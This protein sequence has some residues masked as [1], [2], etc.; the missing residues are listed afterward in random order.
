MK[1]LPII[2]L[3]VATTSSA[4]FAKNKCK[5]LGIAYR[6][7][8]PENFH[9][10]WNQITPENRGF[11]TFVENDRDQMFWEL[12]DVPYEKAKSKG[13]PFTHH[14]FI[15]NGTEPAWFWD[16]GPEEQKE[17]VE[18]WMKEF[19]ERYPDAD[20][21]EVVNEPLHSIPFYAEAL[22]G[23]GETGWDWLIW[24]FQKARQYNPNAKL[25]LNEYD[26]LNGVVSIDDYLEIINLL[27]QRGLIDYIG[28]Q[29]HHLE[30]TTN[31]TLQTNLDKLAATDLPILITA[32]DV[33]M[34]DDPGAGTSAFPSDKGQYARYLTQFPVIWEHPSVHGVTLWGYRQNEMIAPKAYLIRADGT[35]RPALEWLR[36][37]VTKQEGGL[38][39]ITGV[40]EETEKSFKVYPNPSEGKVSI[41]V[42]AEFVICDLVG[43]VI[44]K[45]YGPTVV[46]LPAGIHIV[47][48]GQKTEKLVIR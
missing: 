13:F 22:G 5:F 44:M 20:Y 34:K 1:Y 39:C 14:A 46:D 47:R 4:Q 18:E 25:V 7:S 41:D 6:S 21:I 2:L 45:G 9:T 43:K 30:L 40:D 23:A 11:W 38:F 28:E 33:N 37:Y 19:G 26:V 17:E 31:H 16:L 48:S 29:G 27:K 15:W 12:I 35:E 10:Y 32:Y 24:A 36:S 3:F 8:T 42:D